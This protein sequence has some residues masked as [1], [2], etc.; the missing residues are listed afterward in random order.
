MLAR[1]PM[2][3]TMSSL[4]KPVERSTG[5]FQYK[6]KVW[7]ALGTTLHNGFH[8]FPAEGHNTFRLHCVQ[9]A[10]QRIE[11]VLKQRVKALG[12]HLSGFSFLVLGRANV[13][14]RLSAQRS[15]DE[16]LIP[17]AAGQLHVVQGLFA[18]ASGARQRRQSSTSKPAACRY[19]ELRNARPA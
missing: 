9:R 6:S 8:R 4:F 1:F 18:P 19:R 16:D 13:E 7:S 10:E 12:E 11:P 5:G 14:L 3:A 15:D 17:A 2:A